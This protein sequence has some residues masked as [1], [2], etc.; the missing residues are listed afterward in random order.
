V[1]LF[2]LILSAF[3]RRPLRSLLT[4]CGVGIALGTYLS[5]QTLA[6]GLEDGWKGT[7]VRSGTDII[8]SQDNVF[9][10]AV[11]ERLGGE[12][13][14]VPGVRSVTPLLW[15]LSTVDARQGTPLVGWQAGAFALATLEVRG[16][17]FTAGAPEALLGAY[18]A[19]RLGK[20]VGDTITIGGERLTVVGIFTTPNI[21]E[22]EAV[23]VPLS[24]LQRLRGTPGIVGAFYVAVERTG[25]AQATRAAIDRVVHEVQARFPK[26]AAYR[27]EDFARNNEII[28]MARATAWGT[29]VIAFG[30]A[31]LG[32][33]NTMS[34]AVLERT[35]EI[36]LLR[37]VG[38]HRRRVLTLL[39]WESVVLTTTG[40]CVG[41]LL[42]IAGLRGLTQVPRM[43]LI[44]ITGIPPDL[45]L[46]TL[47]LGV[48]L[49]VL[50]GLLPAYRAA[51]IAPVEALR[52]E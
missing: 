45:Y 23:Y 14:K 32:V 35:R 17:L 4:V 20:Q 24:I 2:T 19:R 43:R 6:R 44:A 25:D 41:I 12:I 3:R 52:Y 7:Y 33:V 8:V 29:S 40:G 46:Q 5:F 38:W 30:V 42:A 18:V 31:M 48:V 13:R 50:G 28:G 15:G 10:G 21:L 34:M 36:G 37:A 39:L 11:E 26:L 51:R 27:T 22:L 1:T 49:G 9:F 47:I 16:R